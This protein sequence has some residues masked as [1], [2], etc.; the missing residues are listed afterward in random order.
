[1]VEG[2][3]ADDSAGWNNSTHGNPIDAGT[4]SRWLGAFGLKT[5]RPRGTDPKRPRGYSRGDVEPV[6]E[7]Y[8][9]SSSE[10]GGPVGP[11]G[12]SRVYGDGSA[13]QTLDGPPVRLV[14]PVSEVTGEVAWRVEAMRTQL[15]AN[16]ALPFLVA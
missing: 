4:L 7:R 11:S 3:L 9:R 10:N 13:S 6:V 16:G 1:L 5:V 14:R 15:P 2:L 8:L 12:P